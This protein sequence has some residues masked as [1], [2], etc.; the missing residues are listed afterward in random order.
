VKAKAD[1]KVPVARAICD[2]R[3]AGAI[4]RRLLLQIQNE[5]PKKS[6]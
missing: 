1:A 2:V 4:V 3:V 6:K 5:V